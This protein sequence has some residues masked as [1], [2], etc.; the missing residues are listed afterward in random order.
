MA[1]RDWYKCSDSECPEVGS[2]AGDATAFLAE[3]KNRHVRASRAA[4][5]RMLADAQRRQGH[6]RNLAEGLARRALRQAAEAY[7]LAEGTELA[8]AAH[9]EL[10]RMGRWVRQTFGCELDFRDG[11]YST[12]CPVKLADMRLGFSPGFSAQRHC[13][14]CGDDLAECPHL[15]HR[16]YW[17]K[18]GPGATGLCAVCLR[19][20]CTHSVNRL[21]RVAVV[22]VISEID[23]LREVSMVDVPANPLARPISLPIDATRLAER[24]GA[25]F[26]AGM[27]VNCDHCLGPYE[28]PPDD[29]GM[30]QSSG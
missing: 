9:R 16:L 28:G 10:H 27:P 20:S 12:S 18:G 8:L 3:Q 19:D 22:S 7:W 2:D 11:T 23:E 25:A 14:I 29:L 24:F 26:R 6:A 4:A 5:R 30:V 1:D 21:Y 13:S 15:R 17:V